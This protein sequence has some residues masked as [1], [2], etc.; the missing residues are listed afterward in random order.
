[1]TDI[2][3]SL[4]SFRTSPHLDTRRTGR[5]QQLNVHH[6]RLRRRQE[7]AADTTALAAEITGQRRTATPRASAPRGRTI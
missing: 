1:M 4:A 3:K 6:V 2:I 5:Y 7:L